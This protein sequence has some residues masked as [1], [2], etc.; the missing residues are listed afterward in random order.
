MEARYACRTTPLLA[1]GF[2]HRSGHLRPLRMVTRVLEGHRSLR[3]GRC[4]LAKR[5]LGWPTSW[6]RPWGAG[7]VAL[8]T[9]PRLHTFPWLHE[10]SQRH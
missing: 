1:R 4:G 8:A 10:T 3:L 2:D 5:L 7:S 6:A 9:F